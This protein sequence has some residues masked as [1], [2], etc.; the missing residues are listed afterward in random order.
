MVI[1]VPPDLPTALDILAAEHDITVLA[2]GTDLMV[3]INYG[4]RHPESMLSLRRVNELTGWGRDGDQL[5]LGSRLTYREFLTPALAALTPGLAA[6]ARTV[7]SP[8]IRATGT[9]GGNLATA[10]PAGDLLPMLV[11]L[12]A[13]V[14]LVSVSGP[15]EV[16][17]EEFLIGP[18]HTARHPDELIRRVRV[19]VAKGAQEFLKVGT[20][21]A[22]VIAVAS[23][24]FVVDTS[25]QTVC[26]ALGSVGPVVVRCAEADASL[27]G[28]I[29]WAGPCLAD[30][31]AVDRYTDLVGAAARPIDDHRSTAAYRRHAV[32]VLAGRALRRAF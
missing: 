23:C 5:W 14:E 13:S 21:N 32:S 9:L 12:G 22:M 3:A 10:S 31:S 15:R 24:A 2:G 18:R 28:C 16:P 19:P 7:G 6:A 11:A 30:G 4:Q 17:I 29:D 25:A 27:Q 20:R 26:T 1:H 8:Q